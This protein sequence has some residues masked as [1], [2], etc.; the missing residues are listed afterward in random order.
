MWATANWPPAEHVPPNLMAFPVPNHHITWTLAPLGTLGVALL[1]ICVFRPVWL[2]SL[3]FSNVGD[4][5][6]AARRARPP[7]LDGLP[8]AEPSYNL[9]PG[10]VGYPRSCAA[11]YLCVSAR[12]AG[13]LAVLQCG[14]RRIGPSKHHATRTLM[15]F[16]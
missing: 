3:R 6:L 2:S 15:P 16:P 13:K 11:I 12:V 9:D 14:R 7:Q 10:T 1:Y 5:E 8:G 4:G